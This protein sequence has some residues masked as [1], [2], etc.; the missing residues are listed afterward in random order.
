MLRSVAIQRVSDGLGFRTGLDQLI[1][2]QLQEAQ[3][4]LEKGKTLPLFLLQENQNAQ[5]CG[6]A[7]SGRVAEWF[8]SGRAG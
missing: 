4:D 7:K 6:G 3:R 8:Y 2:L 1:I 5:S